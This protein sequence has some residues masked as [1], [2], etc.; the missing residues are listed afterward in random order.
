MGREQVDKKQLGKGE[1]EISETSTLVNPKGR[2]EIKE[3]EE[4]SWV[5]M[6]NGKIYD[7][8]LY[9]K[10]SE[11]PNYSYPMNVNGVYAT[12]TAAITDLNL[13]GV[14]G[15]TRFLLNDTVL[16]NR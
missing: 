12:I 2:K 16:Y 9:I 7:G 5:P 13:R 1:T 4:V 15:A 8:P 11:S 3:V 10:K 6:Q 14:S